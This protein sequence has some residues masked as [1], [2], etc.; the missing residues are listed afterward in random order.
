VAR[1]GA[2]QRDLLIVA[3]AADACV[4]P[5]SPFCA[6]ISLCPLMICSIYLHRPIKLSTGLCAGGGGAVPKAFCSPQIST[7]LAGGPCAT[8]HKH[9]CHKGFTLPAY[10]PP[11]LHPRPPP[12]RACR[13]DEDGALRTP[14]GG[15]ETRAP[16]DFPRIRDALAGGPL[17]SLPAS[18]HSF[19]MVRGS[20]GTSPASSPQT[21]RPP[22][23]APSSILVSPRTPS[24]ASPPPPR[25][26]P[27]CP[28]RPSTG[29][30]ASRAPRAILPSSRCNGEGRGEGGC[31]RSHAEGQS[32]SP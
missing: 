7:P 19:G 5:P 30:T 23:I 31:R 16:P 4:F 8:K 21:A 17:A 32:P 2:L 3:E 11:S 18:A 25:P 29:S 20:V 6:L 1:L 26:S 14:E 12:R 22:T 15:E 10:P 13:W 24:H 27:A 9:D 28:R